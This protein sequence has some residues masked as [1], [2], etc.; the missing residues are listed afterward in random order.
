M[1]L[2]WPFKAAIV[3]LVLGLAAWVAVPRTVSAWRAHQDHERRAAFVAEM[4]PTAQVLLRVTTPQG[5]VRCGSEE[6]TRIN[7]DLCWQGP[8]TPGRASLALQEE[9][10]RLGATAVSVHCA[11]KPA[12]PT[13]CLVEG[14]VAGQKFSALAG[15]PYA[16][17]PPAGARF[18]LSGNALIPLPLPA[19]APVPPERA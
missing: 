18:H 17:S 5:A 1:T 2:R 19:W 16:G 14:D 8:Q 12:G 6:G 7:G 10:L 15:P 9:L 4:A 11:R 3:V 13:F